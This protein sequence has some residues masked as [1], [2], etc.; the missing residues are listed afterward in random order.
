MQRI[1]WKKLFTIWFLSSGMT[2]C[3]MKLDAAWAVNLENQGCQDE[4]K[5]KMKSLVNTKKIFQQCQKGNLKL[6]NSQLQQFDLFELTST[7]QIPLNITQAKSL[8]AQSNP[9]VTEN[10][11]NNQ[12]PNATPQLETQP[13]DLLPSSP[14]PIDQLL[15]QP[16]KDKIERLE[17]LRRRLRQG[18]QPTADEL[19]SFAELGL[20][21]RP[22]P[23]PQPP[24]PEFKPIGNLQARFGYYHTS[25]VFSSDVDPV[26]DGLIFSGLRLATVYFPLGSRT[27]V[28]GS[29]EGNL[30]RYVD[31]SVFNY[32]QVKFNLSVYQQLSPRMYGEIGWS[33][34]QLFFANNSDRFRAGDR[35]LG[36]NSLSLSLG[37]RDPLTPKLMLNSFYEFKLNFA[38]PSSRDRIINSLWLSLNYNLQQ[39][40]QVGLNYQFNLSNFTQ[41]ERDDHYHRLFGHLNYQV[42]DSSRINLQSGFTFGDSTDNNINFDGW[43]FTINYNWQL[44]QF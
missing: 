12:Q 9:G 23:L 15:D 1:G 21:V 40:L 24:E 31:Q 22:R 28:N 13:R 16:Q 39:P 32:N 38:D 42:S 17:R 2:V 11:S 10:T 25:N 41:R 6:V 43:F 37:R 33:N 27:F 26:E 4:L 20:R 34:Q 14:T 5:S 29:I 8:T 3:C 36:E 18:R 19:N 44:G 7:E 35:F 30:I